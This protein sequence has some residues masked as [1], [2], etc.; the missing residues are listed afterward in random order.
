MAVKSLESP[1]RDIS[2]ARPVRKSQN[3]AESSKDIHIRYVP[4]GE[5]A[6]ERTSPW[7]RNG[8]P[9]CK[10]QM[11]TVVSSL[12]EAIRSP[13][14]ESVTDHT[15]SVWPS[16]GV[17]MDCPLCE[18]QMRTVL[19]SLPEAIRFPSGENATDNT[20]FE[21]RPSR[22][23]PMD[24]ALCESQMHTFPSSLPE[25]ICFPSGENA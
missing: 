3:Q 23:V 8:G 21:W 12:P 22:D 14:G 25:A 16:K 15:Q 7:L 4:S 1:S 17:P 13:S 11:R 24:F 19:S 20:V 18:S 9:L 10:S 2:I 6:T 5:S